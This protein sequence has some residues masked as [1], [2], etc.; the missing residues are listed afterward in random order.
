[1]TGQGIIELELRQKVRPLYV[2]LKERF[3][4]MQLSNDLILNS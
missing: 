2:E 1:M 4:S 3:T